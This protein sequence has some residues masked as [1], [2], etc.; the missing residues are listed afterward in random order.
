MTERLRRYAAALAAVVLMI[1]VAASQKQTEPPRHVFRITLGLTDKKT[2][3]WSGQVT[4]AGGEVTSIA[5]W[6]FEG[7]DAVEGVRGWKCRSHENIAPGEHFPLTPASGKAPPAP[8]QPWANGVTLGV[9]GEAPTLT[10][11]LPAG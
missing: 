6:R 9:R 3:D 11:T 7:K 2:A 8:K 1:A 4:V 10:I 5:G